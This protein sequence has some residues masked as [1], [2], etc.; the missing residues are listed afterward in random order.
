MGEDEYRRTVM[1]DPDRVG[2]VIGPK[3]ASVRKIS[4]STGCRVDVSKDMPGEVTVRGE[5]VDAVAS[6]LDWVHDIVQGPAE[7]TVWEGEVAKVVEV[8]CAV[9][10]R[11]GTLEGFVH[12]SA[13]LDG[14]CE[15]VSDVVREGDVVRVMVLPSEGGRSRGASV[16]L[17]MRPSDVEG[18]V[19]RP[20]AAAGAVSGGGGESGPR[21]QIAKEEFPYLGG[22][23]GGLIG[24]S[25]PT[26]ADADM[27]QNAQWLHRIHQVML[28]SPHPSPLES[29]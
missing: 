2:A 24:D 16:R 23:A 25:G 21:F 28:S 5:D 10:F 14:R 8:G 20:Y 3:G 12:I 13:V 6:A 27:G 19:P 15:A 11:E 17:S 1:I 29:S 7:G 4:A 18:A 26:P 9:L 22:G